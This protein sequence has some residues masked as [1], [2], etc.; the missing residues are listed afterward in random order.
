L[1][2][3]EK[4]IFYTLIKLEKT[5]SKVQEKKK[6]RKTHILLRGKANSLP[7]K[8]AGDLVLSIAKSKGLPFCE[9]D[10]LINSQ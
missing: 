9:E 8:A 1:K 3:H 10:I 6:L 4:E 7:R 5:Q 2:T